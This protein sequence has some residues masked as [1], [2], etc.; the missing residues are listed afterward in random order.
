M[1]KDPVTLR[2]APAASPTSSVPL[3][4]L[5][6][7]A[8]VAQETAAVAGGEGGGGRGGGGGVG[9]LV[10]G[11]GVS[12]D[13]LPLLSNSRGVASDGGSIQEPSPV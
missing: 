2:P 1:C 12:G 11:D 9:V 10:G 7:P 3:A 8:A 4:V 13:R 6:A 5:P